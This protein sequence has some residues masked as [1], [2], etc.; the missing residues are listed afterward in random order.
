M[1]LLN[2]N[3]VSDHAD[4]NACAKA[5]CFAG[6]G[7]EHSAPCRTE[8]FCSYPFWLKRFPHSGQA[9][10]RSPVWMRWWVT[11]PL[12][13][14]KLF[15]HSPQVN[16]LPPWWVFSCVTRNVRWL[17]LFPHSAV[18]LC[19]TTQAG[20]FP[21]GL[22]WCERTGTGWKRPPGAEFAGPSPG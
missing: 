12:L 5:L 10:G 9:K 3:V 13:Q 11:R 21:G 7:P 18:W 22:P 8:P 16:G 14:L 2:V 20:L 1:P 17:K 4:A 15:P 19:T 6:S